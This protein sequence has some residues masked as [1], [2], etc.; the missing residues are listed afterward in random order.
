MQVIYSVRFNFVPKNILNP[1][2]NSITPQT[3][4]CFLPPLL[5]RA[6]S[7]LS[8]FCVLIS[9]AEI[10]PAQASQASFFEKW[11]FPLSSIKGGNCSGSVTWP[12]TQAW[13]ATQKDVSL[14]LSSCLETAAWPPVVILDMFLAVLGNSPCPWKWFFL[15]GSPQI[16]GKSCKLMLLHA[17]W[18]TP[19][20]C[21]QLVLLFLEPS[22]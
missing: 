22:C 18:Y 5:M 14:L 8:A 20:L 16:M 4:A 21:W 3:G 17:K 7:T 12:W 9:A 1:S 19:L 6:A 2:R 15:S 13:P 11:I 10:L